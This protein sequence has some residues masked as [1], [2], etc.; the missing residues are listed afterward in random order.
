[1]PFGAALVFTL[2]GAI[3][4]TLSLCFLIIP[5]AWITF[6]YRP[7]AASVVAK[8]IAEEPAKGGRRH[9]LEVQLAYTVDGREEQAW[10]RLPRSTRETKGPEA[11]AIQDQLALGQ[12]VTCYHDPFNPSSGVVLDNQRLEW[13]MLFAGGC[14]AF[15]LFIGVVGLIASWRRTFPR[16]ARVETAT[17]LHRLPRR[18]YQ[19]LGGLLLILAVGWLT[20]TYLS[21]AL[22][23][24][25][26]LFFPLAILAAIVMIR[27]MV[28]YGSVALPSPERRAA[29]APTMEAR[30]VDL[31]PPV[32]EATEAPVERGHRLPLRLRVDAFS[33]VNEKFAAA[34]VF[35]CFVFLLLAVVATQAIVKATD[36]PRVIGT[37]VGAVLALASIGTLVALGVRQMRR[38]AQMTVEI[39]AHPLRPGGVYQL[40]LAHPDPL[41]L[42]RLAPALL[43]EEVGASGRQKKQQKQR[44]ALWRQAIPLQPPTA[45]G[46]RRGEFA[47]PSTLPA[48]LELKGHQ[49]VWFIVV[50]LGRR[51]L[52]EVR[53]PVTM[54][55]VP[56]DREAYS[57]PGVPRR[58]DD[59][60]GSLWIDDAP[61]FFA[62]GDELKGGWSVRPLDGRPLRTAEMSVLWRTNDAGSEEMGVCHYE[63]REMKDDD[64]LP[65]YGEGRFQV[66][67]PLGPRSFEGELV[68][69]R[70]LVRVRLRY[71]DG[72]ERL[73]EL[74][75]QLGPAGGSVPG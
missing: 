33:V 34:V 48:S 60:A 26:C 37:M 24:G 63:L 16:G 36:T 56:V 5:A 22:G 7:A 44:R 66:R 51:F 27:L 72:D 2:I 18:F 20:V 15:F 62:P 42:G 69:I 21:G 49:I 39:S 54:T 17:V 35:G 4:L 46:E 11:D 10:V 55:A 50:G 8:R 23:F 30:F 9:Y 67:L 74:G 71:A 6:A 19:A 65:L 40:S 1:M 32:G 28:R 14:P 12:E 73:R 3:V 45:A 25:M 70:W 13:N 29:T 64:E 53:C 59:E 52:G 68:K 43:C 47:A 41:V 58:L 31:A 57:G 61:P 38:A 75:F